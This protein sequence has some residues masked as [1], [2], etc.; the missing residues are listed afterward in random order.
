MGKAGSEASDNDKEVK[1]MA[2]DPVCGMEVDE[3]KM[4]ATYDYRG[5]TYYF[6]TQG[7]KEKFSEEPE[8]FLDV[9]K[10]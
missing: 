6:C 8:R 2:M 1:T 4:A 10:K 3:K 9:D 5:K 7:C